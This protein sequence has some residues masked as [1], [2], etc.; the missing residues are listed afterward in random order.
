LSNNFEQSLGTDSRQFKCPAKRPLYDSSIGS[1]GSGNY[2]IVE[3]A[4]EDKCITGTMNSQNL[5][6]IAIC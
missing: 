3:N 5:P 6:R 2:I 4:I 1:S